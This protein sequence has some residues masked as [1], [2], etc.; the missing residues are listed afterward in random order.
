MALDGMVAIV[1]GAGKGI[2]KGIARGLLERGV[3]VV[4]ASRTGADLDAA[5][6]E[7]APLGSVVAKP[8]DVSDAAAVDALV[9]TALD[10]FGA[11]D[12]LVCSHGVL[13]AGRRFA[14]HDEATWDETIA[15]NLKG[16]FLCGRACARVMEAKGFG[17]II[18]ISSIAA[19][20][21][22]PAEAA[23][24]ASKGGVEALTRSMS[25]DLAAQGI[26][27]NAVAPGWVVTPMIEE[28]LSS[29]LEE[30]CNPT[31]RFG[32]PED[33]AGTVAW[34]ADP[35]SS[36][37]TGASIVVDGGQRGVLWGNALPEA[38]RA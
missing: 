17:R 37:V 15:I 16:T 8:T 22:A 29:E 18:N 21:S 38:I 32:T 10:H 33:I 23:Y 3:D 25:L 19:F 2:G 13:H 28:R 11:V 6:A 1:T 34:L 4:I 36:Y 26:T 14:E 7:M 31:R 35:A 5:A 30:R 27:V 9:A 12:I 24:E 20:A